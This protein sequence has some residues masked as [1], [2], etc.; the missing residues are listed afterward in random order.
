[1]INKI[2]NKIGE[3]GRSEVFEWD[4]ESKIIKLAKP[5]TIGE[6]IV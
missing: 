4:D 6:A 3:G 5:N 1:M 2:G